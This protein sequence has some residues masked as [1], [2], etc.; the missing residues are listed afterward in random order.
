MPPNFLFLIADDHRHDAIGSLGNPA[1][2]TPTL[3]AL[4]AAGTALTSTYIMGSTSNAVCMPSRAMLMTGR[5]LFRVF[6][7]NPQDV[8]PYPMDPGIPTF[9]QLLRGAGYRTYGV[10]KWHNEPELFARSFDGGGS[11]FFGGM[12]DH[13]AVPLHDYDP[14]G[15]YP[16]EAMTVGDG[17][18]TEVFVDTAIG[19]LH[20]HPA[21]QPFCMYTAFT[22]PHDPRTPPAEFAEMYPPEEI[23]LPPNFARMH[24]F[25]NGHL[26]G[27]DES[28]AAHPRDP[29]EIRQHIADYYGMISHLDAQIGRLLD[30]LAASGHAEDTIVVYAADHGLAVGQHGLLGKQNVYDHSLRVPLIFR[31]P[32]IPAG[33]RREGLCY[34]HDVFPTILDLAGL[35]IPSGCEGASLAPALTGR[36]AEMRDCVFGAFQ[37]SQSLGSDDSTQR[38][39]RR[40]NL[41]LIEAR[42]AGR[43]HR[44]L[45]DLS[46]DPWETRNLAGDP[47]YAAELAD[48]RRV[49]HRERM[50]AGDPASGHA[51][52]D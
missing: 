8:S 16:P 32:G 42:L 18:S 15:V 12:S 6:A 41:K 38:M 23:E 1:V 27:R 20:E 13:D 48:M 34:L 3:D 43:T 10:G 46:V 44:Q 49:L 11:I 21:D 45:F 29:R 36:D 9:P 47:A 7:P 26:H 50:G 25:D 40:G 17:F 2:H 39:V 22:S 35:E 33:Q 51:D 24:P 19:L 31:G 4:A 14:N 52:G 30:A 37:R 5:S 28:L